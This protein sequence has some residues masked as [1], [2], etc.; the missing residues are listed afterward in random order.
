MSSIKAMCTVFFEEPFWVGIY[1]REDDNRYQ[2]CKIIFGNE[3]KGQE[4]YEFMLKNWTKLKFSSSIEEN[5]IV[6][7]KIN[8]K[9]MQRA[10]KKQ[11]ENIGIGTKA[12]QTLKLQQEQNKSERKSKAR[13]KK[14]VDAE[15]KF[16]SRQEKRKQKHKGH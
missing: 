15:Q 11:L 9:K 4:V 5:S 16:E 14:E 12:Q 13:T 6:E 2:V 10:I 7:K 3:P 1:E 8:P